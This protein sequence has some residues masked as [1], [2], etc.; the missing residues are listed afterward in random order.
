MERNVTGQ[1]KRRCDRN[2][3]CGNRADNDRAEHDDALAD[4]VRLFTDDHFN[5]LAAEL[6]ALEIQQAHAERQNDIVRDDV[7]DRAERRAARG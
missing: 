5:R 6:I 1:D 3:A 7:K 4:G 2:P